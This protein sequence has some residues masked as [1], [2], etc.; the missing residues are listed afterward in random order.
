MRRYRR[1][2]AF[3]PLSEHCT[4]ASPWP[5]GYIWLN[6]ERTEC[7]EMY[8]RNW[9]VSW[10]GIAVSNAEINKKFWEEL[11]AYFPWYDTGHIENDASNNSSIVT[12]VFVT[13]IT[14]LPSR[15]L[16]T[17]G[18]FLPSRCL[19]TIGGFF[20]EPLPG[21]DRGIFT[22]PLPSND[23][24]DTQTHAHTDTATWFHKPTLIFS[25]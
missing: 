13:A 6:C 11:I 7:D 3:I 8:S 5:Y 12:C 1:L 25:N 14:F 2:W 9:H 23:R 24:G 10:V 16:A 4:V 18:G 21:N 20:S 22:Q 17:I 19:V 15:F